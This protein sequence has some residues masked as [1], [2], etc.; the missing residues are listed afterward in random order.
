MR[1]DQAWDHQTIRGIQFLRIRHQIRRNGRDRSALNADIDD[2]K[3]AAPKRAGIT[4]NEIHQQP[5]GIVVFG[6][7]FSAILP[8]SEAHLAPEPASILKAMHKF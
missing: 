4:D 7:S 6:G 3:L 2:M 5:L 1:L 8:I